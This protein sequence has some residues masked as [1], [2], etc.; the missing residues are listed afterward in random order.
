MT[1]ASRTT[2]TPK[3][4]GV[5]GWMLALGALTLL[6]GVVRFAGLGHQSFWYDEAWTDYLVRLHPG[7][8]L[9]T[10][11]KTESTPPLYYMIA[12]AWVR[13]VGRD[14]VGLRSISALA[15]TATVPI[16]YAAAATLATRR[17]GLVAAALAATSPIL[18]WY[19]Q[20]ARSYILMVM[21]AAL[22]LLCF[23]RARATP[24]RGWL[25]AWGV[26]SAAALATHYFAVFVVAP[27]AVL[28]LAAFAPARGAGVTPALRRTLAAVGGVTL[29]G[30]GLSLLALGQHKNARWIN[31]I[32]LGHR[33]GELPREFVAGFP[34]A[35]PWVAVAGGAIALA[36]VVL[37]VV[38]GER[39][40]RLGALV[41]GA[42]GAAA[43][44][45]PL[46]LTAGGVD[47]LLTRN[48]LVA[49]LPLAIVVAAGLGARR[50]AWPG[51]LLAVCLCAISLLAVDAVARHPDLQR[52][53]WRTLATVLGPQRAGRAILIPRAGFGLPLAVYRSGTWLM[54]SPVAPLREIDVVTASSP[55][56][57]FVWWGGIRSI[58]HLRPWSR[59]PAPGFALA[60]RTRAGELTVSRF[61]AP[62][63]IPV[64]MRTLRLAPATV[65]LLD[66][67][68]S[69]VPR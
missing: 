21:L 31:G 1:A 38:R 22:S 23:A 34:P 11:P 63:P 33:L 43:I 52:P 32:P 3:T 49:W 45:I 26:S 46:A 15:G 13:V 5:S 48:V 44:L 25:A 18:V 65:V 8:L 36:A 20:E 55:N 28:L 19:S 42:I 61:L 6:A 57:P 17:I 58:P 10:I 27:E 51:T 9:K 4:R 30:A 66:R 53:P 64:A 41:A 39:R 68:H 62:H 29:V 7:E 69:P 16:A 24:T 40:E 60:G 35:V 50:A 56:T 67:V 12:W 54:R 47:Y 37:L 14:E 59:P 2:T